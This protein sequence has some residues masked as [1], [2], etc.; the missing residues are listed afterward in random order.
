M[1]P[2]R[3]PWELSDPE[4]CIWPVPTLSSLIRHRDKNIPQTDKSFYEE[5]D[6]RLHA[7]P[8]G[9]A[10]KTVFPAFD[11][12]TSWKTDDY[13]RCTL[14]RYCNVNTMYH[15]THPVTQKERPLILVLFSLN[16]QHRWTP[17]HVA[18]WLESIGL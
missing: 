9:M 15:V 17:D 11:P 5:I 1:Q 16:K 2:L 10:Y 7:S 14:F 18:E 6:G 3:K 13:I 8:L 12:M 4:T